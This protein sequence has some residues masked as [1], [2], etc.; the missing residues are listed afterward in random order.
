M[1]LTK[2][3]IVFIVAIT[4]LLCQLVGAQGANMIPNPSFEEGGGWWNWNY[5]GSGQ[6]NF[7]DSSQALFGS[8]S[9][10]IRDCTGNV[11]IARDLWDI[12]SDLDYAFSGWIK[13]DFLTPSLKACLRVIWY[14][15]GNWLEVVDIGSVQGVRDWTFVSMVFKSSQIPKG[16][17]KITVSC[18]V[19]GGEPG[20][21]GIAYF[22]GLSFSQ[23]SQLTGPQSVQL[24]SKYQDGTTQLS[25]N[26]AS[27]VQS[28]LI[29][30]GITENVDTLV[31]K[32]QNTT[33]QFGQYENK[34]NYYRVV[35]VDG[36]FIPSQYSNAVKGD[37]NPPAQITAFTCDDRQTG[38]V[39]L[40]WEVPALAPDGDLPAK[41]T[42]YRLRGEE[43][44]RENIQDQ[45]TITAEDEEFSSQ[46]GAKIEYW[47]PAPGDV[48]YFY[49]ITTSDD[50]GNESLPGPIVSGRPE[51]DLVLPQSPVE[52][53]AFATTGL[54]GEQLPWGLVLLTWQEPTVAAA[55]GDHPRY[56]LIYR[57]QSETAMIPIA[58]VKAGLPAEARTYSDVTAT[59][60][61]TYYYRI[62]AVDKAANKSE[63]APYLEATPLQPK[64][65]T[66]V[67][68]INGMVSVDEET[69]QLSWQRVEPVA[70]EVQGYHVEYSQDQSFQ[71]AVFSKSQGN[72]SED[73]IACQI[74]S[75][76]M[77]DGIWYWRVWTEFASGVVSVSETN[78]LTVME[79]KIAQT[80]KGS[81]SYAQT[82]KQ[83]FKRAEPCNL[84]FVLKS[85]A[86]VSV[87]VFNLKGKLVQELIRDAVLPG[88]QV[89]EFTWNGLDSNGRS[90][91]DGLYLIRIKAQADPENESVIVK[92]VQ[93]FN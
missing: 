55:D 33:Y 93:I 11:I 19:Q 75:Q 10:S 72:T 73:I 49:T 74:P 29:Y 65:A 42:I 63:N 79:N 25:W 64:R 5:S 59:E 46:V 56:Y 39:I 61:I 38:V 67:S 62:C 57:G 37:E 48:T 23:S 2:V 17:D 88:A 40:G 76:L 14:K 18:N 32:T 60:G 3:K 54:A 36:N 69:I 82:Q 1:T 8:K 7:S 66:V 22:D 92:R 13:T 81:I 43:F 41:Y 52:P 27:Q 9:A 83:V 12:N 70:D 53:Q 86:R 20:A 26:E 87:R 15:D 77:G 47:Y 30:R 21:R 85:D 44:T 89:L 16:A 34:F 91:P 51:V 45:V 84:Y 24:A 35:A 68:P 31:A 90:V 71:R 78:Q 28:Y 6:L 80:Q 4:M 50:A 58:Q